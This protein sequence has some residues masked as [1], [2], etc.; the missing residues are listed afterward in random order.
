MKIECKFAK[1][2][3]N[4]FFTKLFVKSNTFDKTAKNTNYQ[5]VQRMANQFETEIGSYIC[6]DL[7]QKKENRSQ[8][9]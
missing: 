6:A 8:A 1:L 4:E 3:C 2:C 7:L 5:A 9:L